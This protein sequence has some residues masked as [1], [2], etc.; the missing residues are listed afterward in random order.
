[1]EIIDLNSININDMVKFV[2]PNKTLVDGIVKKVSNDFL[3]IRINIRQ[4][5]FIIFSKGQSIELILI[6][7]RQA[8]KCGSIVLGCTQNDFEQ[9]VLI[10]IPKIILIIDRREFTRLPIVMDIEYSPLPDEMQYHN[11]NSVQARYFRSFKKAYTV[12]ISAGGVYFIVSKSDTNNKFAL[13][14]LSLKNEKITA[15]CEKIRTDHADDSKHL[16]VAYKYDDIN[17][18]HR[19][20][21][22]DFVSEKSKENGSAN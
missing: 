7:E 2:T 14:S 4:D 8:I 20:L 1:M 17:P 5:D 6:R 19:Q 18:N 10:S 12:N 16:K 22:L 3:G 15:L 21:I 13:V 11:L 9:I